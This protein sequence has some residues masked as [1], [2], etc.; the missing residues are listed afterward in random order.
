MGE[1]QGTAYTV[2]QQQARH[3][4]AKAFEAAPSSSPN[5]KQAHREFHGVAGISKDVTQNLVTHKP[6]G[7][8]SCRQPFPRRLKWVRDADHWGGGIGIG[9]TPI[10]RAVAWAWGGG[11]G[12]GL[13]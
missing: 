2:Q 10:P 1:D 12:I 11:M 6:H 7:N 5:Q 9:L 13:T 4:E 8:K 3:I